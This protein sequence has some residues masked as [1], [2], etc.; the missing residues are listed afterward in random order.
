M[1][2]ITVVVVDTASLATRESNSSP[3]DAIK[4]QQ[5]EEVSCSLWSWP[6]KAKAKK[7]IIK[8]LESSVRF[9]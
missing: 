4:W 3:I 5:V 9:P 1:L 6:E 8:S 7:N 2:D